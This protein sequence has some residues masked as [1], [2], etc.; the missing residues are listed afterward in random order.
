MYYYNTLCRFVNLYCFSYNSAYLIL[1]EIPA[2]V[3]GPAKEKSR[4]FSISYLHFYY[5][6][7]P[8]KSFITAGLSFCRMLEN[9][10]VFAGQLYG[11][12]IL[13]GRSARYFYK[14]KQKSF[15]LCSSLS[16]PENNFCF[17]SYHI[18]IKI[19]TVFLFLCSVFHIRK[20]SFVIQIPHFSP[21]ILS[22]L[23]YMDRILPD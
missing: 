8:A 1:C 3:H 13:A 6:R 23:Q 7:F 20:N 5:G 17:L 9:I 2:A 15:P 11:S 22:E 12:D 19:P 4:P 14:R 21:N 16:K 18:C 10:P